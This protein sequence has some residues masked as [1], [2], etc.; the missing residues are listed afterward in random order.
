M[1]DKEARQISDPP[2]CGWCCGSCRC[3][4]WDDALDEFDIPPAIPN[5]SGLGAILAEALTKA[6][7]Q[8]Q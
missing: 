8:A 3:D 5:N 4:Q 1:T 6:K 7:E 2:W